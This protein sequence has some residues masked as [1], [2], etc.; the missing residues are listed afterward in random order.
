[1]GTYNSYILLNQ[2]RN[3]T[4]I[5]IATLKLDSSETFIESI[6]TTAICLAGFVGNISIATIILRYKKMQTP[7]NWLVFNLS[8]CAL[9]IV[10]I[11]IPYDLLDDIIDFPFGQIGCKYLFMPVMEHF[12]AVCVLTHAALGVARYIA[13][14]QCGTMFKSVSNRNIR[15]TIC[16]IWFVSFLVLSST[17]MGF[18]GEFFLHKGMNSQLR[19]VLIWLKPSWKRKLYRSSV[20]VLTY[21]LPTT[22]SGIS[23]YK[24]HKIV[25]DNIETVDG[26]LSPDLA[27]MRRKKGGKLTSTFRNMYLSITITTFP[28]QLFMFLV[29]FNMVPT[30]RAIRLVFNVLLITYYAQ[31]VINPFVLFYMSEEFRRHKVLCCHG[32]PNK[33]HSTQTIS[34]K[35]FD[36]LDNDSFNHQQQ[37]NDLPLDRYRQIVQ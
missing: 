1:M 17:L 32:S 33:K 30:F 12:A 15:I 18:L 22:I 27:A 2:T 16:L 19:C 34:T 28:L 36:S 31:V 11:V 13:I 21:L 25:S 4:H 14:R 6:L 20:F 29:D 24:I 7:I 10:L 37:N 35:W 23:Y 9:A 26:H 5:P 3:H 8:L